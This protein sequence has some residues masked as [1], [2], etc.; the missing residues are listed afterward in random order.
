MK[1]ICYGKFARYSLV[2]LA[3]V[4]MGCND[5]DNEEPNGGNGENGNVQISTLNIQGAEQL[6]IYDASKVRST[7]TYEKDENGNSYDWFD[8][9]V[10]LKVNSAGETYPVRAYGEDGEPIE[11]YVESIDYLTSNYV[12]FK[13]ENSALSYLV[14]ISD[15]K[16]FE[17]NSF[18][19]TEMVGLEEDYL[20]L[21][22]CDI[23][24]K[25]YYNI[26]VYLPES[27]N[28][29]IEEFA[30]KPVHFTNN[31]IVSGSVIRNKN[32]E[33]SFNI[34]SD[35]NGILGVNYEND[36]FYYANREGDMLM[37]A[38]IVNGQLEE[39]SFCAFNGYARY[40]FSA[41]QDVVYVVDEFGIATYDGN[42]GEYGVVS[43]EPDWSSFAEANRLTVRK[44]AIIDKDNRIYIMDYDSDQVF[45]ELFDPQNYVNYAIQSI[46]YILSSNRFS[47][48]ALRLVDSK[49]VL[50]SMD[51][52]TDGMLIE[53]EEYDNTILDIV[54]IN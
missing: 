31:Y 20:Y 45:Y 34:S 37:I 8:G 18:E 28:V 22:S 51:V 44:F 9:P 17:F 24:G 1:S 50:L 32:T 36:K 2:A 25:S 10:V 42:T 54:P 46:Q 41:E 30:I 49:K 4:L 40:L 43:W 19:Y 13:L 39:K 38:T 48:N 15:G 23:N 29:Q 12:L 21:I 6:M 33:Q 53:V 27:G 47:I 5:S 35:S 16:A 3:I 11:Y 52:M 14:R 7:R 26:R